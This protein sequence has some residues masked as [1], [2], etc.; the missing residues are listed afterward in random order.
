MDKDKRRG[1]RPPKYKKA[2]I[3]RLAALFRQ[4]IDD[5]E[6]P[7]VAE[8]AYKNHIDRTLLYNREEFG[9]L[10]RECLG[11]KEAALERGALKG[12]LRERM[13][14]FSLKQMGWRENLDQTLNGNIKVE[15][16]GDLDKFAD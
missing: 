9:M 3:E 10:L 4:Y 15:L 11:K 12:E 14:V 7:I 16:T 6:I 2:D 1:G 13:A 5:N 8:F